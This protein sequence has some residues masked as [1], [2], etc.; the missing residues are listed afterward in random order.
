MA[1]YE[2]P[3]EVL[4]DAEK[5]VAWARRSVAFVSANDSGKAD[6]ETAD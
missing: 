2:V 5:L 3:D 6:T 1:Y 4:E